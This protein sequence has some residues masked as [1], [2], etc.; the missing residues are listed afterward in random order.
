MQIVPI[1][2]EV[3]PIGNEMASAIVPVGG[4]IR[5]IG[6]EMPAPDFRSSNDPV[7]ATALLAKQR[8]EEAAAAQAAKPSYFELGSEMLKGLASGLNPFPILKAMYD[9]SSEHYQAAEAAAKRGDYLHMVGENFSAAAA[10]A[11]TVVS[12]LIG[13]QWA[14]FQKAKAAYDKGRYSEAAGHTAAGLLPLVGP[15]AGQAGEEIGTGD[16]RT[17]AHGAGLGVAAARPQLPLDIASGVA[18]A[19]GGAASAVGR[20]IVGK[21]NLNPA[22]AASNAFAE[23]HGVPLDAAT[24]TGSKWMRA[25]EKRVSSSIGGEA[26]ATDL[27]RAQRE[28]LDRVGGELAGDVNNAGPGAPGPAVFPEEAAEGVRGSI[29]DLI[30]TLHDEASKK[31]GELRKFEADPKHADSVAT[32]AAPVDALHDWQKAQLRRINHE[33]DASGYV[34]QNYTHE[35]EYSPRSGGAKVYHDI[36]EQLG[37]EGITRGEL[38]QQIEEFFGGGQQTAA[39]KAALE[40]ARKRF[41]GDRTISTPELP[42]SAFDVPTRLEAG[43][44]TSQVM[45][46]AVD[47]TAAKKALIPIRDRMGAGGSIAPLMGAKATAFSAL[48]RLING[49]DHA[50]L[51]VVDSA[52]GDLKA[53]ARGG[54]GGP[55]MSELRSAGQ[56]TA[57]YAVAQL[58][59]LVRDRAAKAG[60]DVL[61]ALEEG[62]SATKAKADVAIV[63]EKLREEPVA[64]FQQMTRAKDGGIKMLRAVRDVAPMKMQDV[65]R[66]WLEQQLEH[67]RREGGFGHADKLWSDWNNLGTETKRILFSAPGQ[68]QA[69][70]RFFLL[71]KRLS[72][73]PNP[74]G[75]AH[76]LTALNVG[77]IPVTAALAKMLYTKRGV[78]ALT[79]WMAG[80]PLRAGTA[81]GAGRA[82]RAASWAA[83][84]AAAKK[85]GIDL[86]AAV[87]LAADADDKR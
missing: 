43:R 58:E 87:P 62:R 28:G 37:H 57:A 54:K 44:K 81:S 45:G 49:P 47:L 41:M 16:P 22:E 51:S 75:T 32:A 50:S 69:L 23:A 38:Q 21:V 71:T 55:V 53:L 12:G 80:G 74:S 59:K 68:T 72:E 77:S 48:Q 56:G 70:D 33:L 63:L 73:N 9:S 4:E 31:Y 19:V 29:K 1:G 61:Q 20:G 8:E 11:K 35:G 83:L 60:P 40:V 36:T 24:A 42:K 3:T 65:A 76:N 66:A 30:T 78:D 85:S 18:R 82:V 13:G 52:L 86:P 26:G 46:L 14:Q 25:A 79:R 34:S 39:V 10:P 6:A 5:G 7:Q 27:I 15:M 84:V 2:G 67:A 64:A 17:M